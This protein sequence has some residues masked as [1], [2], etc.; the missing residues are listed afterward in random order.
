[1]STLAVKYET[2][3]GLVELDPQTVKNYLVNGNGE[4]TD[5][6]VAM[7]IKLC[8]YQGLNPFLREAY[9]IK[10]SGNNP[11]STVVG[12]DAFT[13]RAARIEECRG[14]RAG[15]GVV[16][17]N[18]E[19]VE[20]EG[21]IILP[22]ERLAG[23]WCEVLRAGWDAPFKTT[24]NLSEYNTGKSMWAKMPATMIRKVAIVQALREAFPDKFQGMYDQAEMGTDGDLPEQ[25]L[26]QDPA[27][28]PI[29]GQQLKA[30]F[31]L[32]G[33]RK[34]AASHIL[35]QYGYE[36]SKDVLNCDYDDIMATLKEAMDAWDEI[37]QAQGEEVEEVPEMYADEL[38][39]EL[40]N[41]EIDIEIEE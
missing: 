24:V 19:Y 27:Q 23:G 35:Q 29:T 10:Y 39:A 11:A 36:R 14:W 30:M 28:R 25:E 40:S 18:G 4:V 37:E 15:V 7:F 8:Q 3:N 12:K 33:E 17:K 21:T 16:T 32:V 34:E 6:E 2:T 38:E 41:I 22:N 20:R 26:P 13:R 5:Q 31:D 1:M 9:L